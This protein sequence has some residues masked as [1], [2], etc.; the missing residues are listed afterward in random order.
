MA[1]TDTGTARL[2]FLRGAGEPPATPTWLNLPFTSAALS[3]KLSSAA[4]QSMR[5]D[6]Q[7][8]GTRLVRA[9]STGDVGLE[10]AYGLW[11]DEIIS[12]LLQ[13]GAV[14]PPTPL[15]GDDDILE[16]GKTKTFFCFE[17]RL[18]AETG[19]NYTLFKDCQIGTLTLDLQA[20]SLASMTIGVVGLASSN[21]T[22]EQAGA[23]YTQYDL[24]DQMDTN[25]A[26]LEMKTQGDVAIDATVQSM[27]LSF[28]NQMRG[29][30]AIGFF[31]NAGNASGRFKATATASLY[32]RSMELYN[33]FIANEGIKLHLTLQDSAGNSYKFEMN[34]VNI[35][36]YEVAVPGADQDLIASVEFQAL[37]ETGN[38]NK[39]VR[40][41]RHTA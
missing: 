35:T 38:N 33:K 9:E 14:Y 17:Q 26:V 24:S 7:F 28:D 25:T 6:R 3:E 11:F 20:N 29:Q 21:S 19:F 22:S 1:L 10:M 2:A 37:P 36:S 18:E 23:T 12:G 13:A 27:S 4:S 15:S 30:Q 34:Y 40:V 39:T 41:I 32:F 16:N 5:D 31:Y 8:A